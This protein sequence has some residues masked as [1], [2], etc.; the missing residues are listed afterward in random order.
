METEGNRVQLHAVFH[1]RVQGVGFRWTIVDYAIRFQVTGTTK[2]LSNGTVEVYAQGEKDSL[3]CFLEAIKK[4]SGL[5]HIDSVTCDYQKIG[6][7]Y[8]NFRII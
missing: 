4:D 5:A 6:T 8:P 7:C 1:G 2:N 3:Q